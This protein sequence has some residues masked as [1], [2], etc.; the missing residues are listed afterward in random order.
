MA[1]TSRTVAVRIAMNRIETKKVNQPP[2]IAV[3]GTK[4]NK[5]Y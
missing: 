4:A 5:I 3:G 2:A 1:A